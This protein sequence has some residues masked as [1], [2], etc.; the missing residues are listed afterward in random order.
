WPRVL[1]AFHV[2]T[3]DGV[4]RRELLFSPGEV[5][6]EVLG[7]ETER[8]LRQL[9]SGT[10][11]LAVARVVPVASPAPGHVDVVVVTKDLWSLRLNASYSI[12]GA[13]LRYLRV[14]PSEQN[15]LGRNT[16][17]SLDLELDPAAFATGLI[18]AD[19]RFLRTP[20]TLSQNAAVIFNRAS[21][22]AE[23]FRSGLSLGR[24]LYA[25]QDRWGYQ[26][27]AAWN[28]Q[29]ARRFRGIEVV[30][31]D[32]PNADAA[33]AQ[34][35]FEYNSKVAS[36]SAEVVRSFG[37]ALKTDLNVNVGLY[38][39]GYRPPVSLP[40]ERRTWLIQNFLPRS[41]SATYLGASLTRYEARYVVL[42]NLDTF[43]LSE[44]YRLGYSAVA[45]L[46]YAPPLV[47]DNHFSEAG[48]SLRYRFYAAD[49]L[50][51][52]SSSAALRWVPE[53]SG[54]G[55]QGA[56]V[57]RRVALELLN[58]S[59]PVGWGRFVSRALLD[60][61]FDDLDN[62]L[63]FLGAVSGLRGVPDAAL[64]G[65]H[66]ALLNLEYRTRPVVVATLHAGLV[67]FWDAGSAFVRGPNFTHT[68]GLG[69]RA[70]F[71]Q[72]DVEPIRIDFGYVVRGDR[73][74]LLDRFSSTFGQVND[75]RPGFLNNPLE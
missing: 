74:P 21:G 55:R 34:V 38:R 69:L 48:A 66:L 49:D 14:R 52:V 37:Y 46:R 63:N 50:F 72:L 43:A 67:F 36:A 24:L 62:P 54:V 6:Q 71:P 39:L 15:F 17:L 65:P 73:P 8:V 2:V 3:D 11:I 42:R 22:K 27:Q 31:L 57:N 70:L 60:L 18:Y 1:N 4:I 47:Y 9:G 51:S 7:R 33:E 75:I 53:A 59:P 25:L 45:A 64:S 13:A 35:P 19:R 58:Y 29:R 61:R 32:Y 10:D 68:V 20:L 56:W 23:G 16:Q 41:E 40:E 44:D 30:R 26:L 12:V 5:Y 28:V